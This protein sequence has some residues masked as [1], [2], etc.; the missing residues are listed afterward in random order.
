MADFGIKI[1]KTFF[2]MNKGDKIE[3]IDF[4]LQ[5]L[6]RVF[7]NETGISLENSMKAYE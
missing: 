1:A 7:K 2:Y 4:L 5:E 6:N 3:E